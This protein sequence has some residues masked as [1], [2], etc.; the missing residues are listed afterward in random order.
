[1]KIIWEEN[2]IKA[3][4]RVKKPDCN[5]AWM[6]GYDPTKSGSNKY[7][8]ISLIDGMVIYLDYTNTNM[9][10]RL[11]EDGLQPCSLVGEKP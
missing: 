3:G 5:E 4:M 8:L 10:Y 9:A 1:M 2:D 6:V 11:T 7:C